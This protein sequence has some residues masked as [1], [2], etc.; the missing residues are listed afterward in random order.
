MIDR[1]K[2]VLGIEA[3]AVAALID[4]IDGRFEQAVKM[5]LSCKGRVVVTGMGKSG[6]YAE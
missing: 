1:A 2:K 6:E 3:E 5:I 4:R